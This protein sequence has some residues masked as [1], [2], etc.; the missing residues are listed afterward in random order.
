MKQYDDELNP[1]PNKV[2]IRMHLTRDDR[3]DFD[4]PNSNETKIKEIYRYIPKL[5]KKSVGKSFAKVFSKFCEKFPEYIG[6]V[7]S[8]ELF[9]KEFAEYN[10]RSYRGH[11]YA[12]YCIDNQ[13]RIQKF[14]ST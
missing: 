4:Y 9:K 11:I 12:E 3:F 8:R 13:G 10:S 2:S 14:K 6:K 1:M 7:N 5:L